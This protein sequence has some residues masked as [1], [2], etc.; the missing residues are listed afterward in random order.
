METEWTVTIVCSL[1]KEIGENREDT[2]THG[3]RWSLNDPRQ[4]LHKSGPSRVES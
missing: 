4:T 2:P 3:H 1:L